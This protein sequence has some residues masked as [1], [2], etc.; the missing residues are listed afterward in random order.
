MPLEISLNI[1]VDSTL[2]QTSDDETGK[3]SFKSYLKDTGVNLNSSNAIKHYQG[4]QDCGFEVDAD[5]LNFC[6]EVEAEGQYGNCAKDGIELYGEYTDY[7]YKP[8]KDAILQ[9]FRDCSYQFDSDS[10]V[11]KGISLS[12]PYYKKFDPKT[13]QIDDVIE[14]NTF[15]STTV[16]REKAKNFGAIILK[17]SGLNNAASVVPPIEIIPGAGSLTH[18]QEVLI[19]PKF[20]VKVIKIL[21][22]EVHLQIQ[23]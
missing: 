18:E 4:S 1:V 6:L 10:I 19:K 9:E 8:L 5:K 22:Q 12:K 7:N 20:T 23:E 15:F 11:Y 2:P 14:V 3:N 21:G 17:I 16:S 13:C